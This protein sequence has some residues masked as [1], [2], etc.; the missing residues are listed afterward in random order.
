[1]NK[2]DESIQGKIEDLSLKGLGVLKGPGG[3]VYFV[4]G[5]WIGEEVEVVVK[6][7]EKN[8]G[9]ARLKK[10]LKAS[11]SRRA[12]PCPHSGFSPGQCGGCPWMMVDER[13]QIQQKSRSFL[14]ELKRAGLVGSNTQVD[15]IKASPKSLEYRNRAR[16]KTDGERVGFLSFGSQVFAP[17]ENCLILSQKNQRLLKALKEKRRVESWEV[18][19]EQ[20]LLEFEIDEELEVD[21]VMPR[22]PRPFRQANATQETFMKEWIQKRLEDMERPAINILELFCGQGTFTYLLAQYVKKE[23]FAFDSFEL[24]IKEL[25]CSKKRKIKAFKEN[26]YSRNAL[27]EIAKRIEKPDKIDFLFLDPPRS[28]LKTVARFTECFP[29]LCQIIYVSCDLSSF[30]RDSKKL[31]ANGWSI[32]NIV[33]VDQFPQ[34]PHLE[35]LSFWVRKK[36]Q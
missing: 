2:I 17:I 13:A 20:G 32:Q 3:F 24:S 15:P 25:R 9:F 30:I 10:L 18:A 16:L 26:L 21:E 23:L 22:R 29:N 19:S 33:A 1:M 28:G 35:V 7:V 34:T 5:V 36:G 8:Y 4:P 14:D 27:R 12:V 6:R 11:P 31:V